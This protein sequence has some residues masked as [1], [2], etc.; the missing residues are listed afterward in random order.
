VRDLAVADV[1]VARSSIFDIFKGRNDVN[2]RNLVI[3]FAVVRGH[4]GRIGRKGE[5][6]DNLTDR[7]LV[8]VAEVGAILGSKNRSEVVSKYV[9]FFVVRNV[10]DVVDR[11]FRNGGWTTRG[12]EVFDNFPEILRGGGIVESFAEFGSKI[13]FR[14]GNNFGDLLAQTVNF[15][16]GSRT[17]GSLKEFC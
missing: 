14:A 11:K 10:E 13:G 7:G 16:F 6:I 12:V 17:V 4:V 5:S 8:V 9:G 3:N 2:I 1:V 15:G